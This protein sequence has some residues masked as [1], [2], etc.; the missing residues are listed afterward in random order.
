VITANKSNVDIESCNEE[1]SL[2]YRVTYSPCWSLIY[3][4]HSRSRRKSAYFQWVLHIIGERWSLIE[5]Q[6]TQ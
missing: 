4:I 1:I 5:S 2:V 6:I 3:Q